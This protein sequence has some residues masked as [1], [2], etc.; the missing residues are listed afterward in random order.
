MTNNHAATDAPEEAALLR[1]QEGRDE[2]R[3]LT[4]LADVGAPATPDGSGPDKGVDGG[5]APAMTGVGVAAM[6]GVDVAAV[7]GVDVAAMT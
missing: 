1:L 6:T 7:T 3:A 4:V 5:P 2:Q